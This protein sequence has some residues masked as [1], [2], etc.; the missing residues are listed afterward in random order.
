MKVYQLSKI[1]GYYCRTG[2]SILT[3]IPEENYEYKWT[4]DFKFVE[5]LNGKKI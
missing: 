2:T 1:N 4:S 5:Q 3:T